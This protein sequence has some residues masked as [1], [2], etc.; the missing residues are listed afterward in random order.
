MARKI[1]IPNHI[2]KRLAREEHK[3]KRNTKSKRKY[4][5]IV[6]EGEKTEPNYFESLKK[7]LPKGVLTSCRIDIEG[8]GRNTL[9]LVKESIK[10]KDRLENETSLS[11]DKIWVVFDRDSF[12]SDNFNEAINLCKNSSPEIGCAWT[13]EAF[14][15]W[16]LLHFHF[17]NT[18]I[19]REMYQKLIEGN[20]KQKIGE[21]Y[22]YQ[23]NSEKM[24]DL[25]RE[26]GS[27]ELA[28]K[29]ATKLEKEFKGRVDFSNHNPCTKVH[30]LVAELFGL[31]KL[32]KEE[33]VDNASG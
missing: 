5:L 27:L 29:F 16:Y 11:I 2:Q 18:A 15:L 32:L 28:I 19:N 12:E 7:D 21:D 3:R 13:N 17:Y 22:K 30:H 24:Y 4:F 8:T 9:S 20:L 6:C 1:K 23:K 33:D 14:E 31:E 10:M 25:L 26:N